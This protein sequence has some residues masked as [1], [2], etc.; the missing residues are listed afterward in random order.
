M[1]AAT[2]YQL[3]NK[4]CSSADIE[5][6]QNRPYGVIPMNYACNL[7]RQYACYISI[8]DIETV[9]LNCITNSYREWYVEFMLSIRKVNKFYALVDRHYGKHPLYFDIAAHEYMSAR[10]STPP[11]THNRTMR[12]IRASWLHTVIDSRSTPNIVIM[13]GMTGDVK[14]VLQR[15]IINDD[16]KSFEVIFNNFDIDP[17]DRAMYLQFAVNHH[18]TSII[19]KYTHELH[20]L[21]LMQLAELD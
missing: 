18:A 17:V 5:K 16:L 7:L 15:I 20:L 21:Q 12:N 4:Y 10:T 11:A 2:A 13:C 1:S 14:Q 9:M 19:D 3:V 6:Y 8:R